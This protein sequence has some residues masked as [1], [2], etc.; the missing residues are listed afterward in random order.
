MKKAYK[1]FIPVVLLVAAI[2]S[3]CSSVPKVDWTL[4]ISGDVTN[5]MEISYKE[6]TQMS[7]T[8]LSD[9]MM[10]KSLGEDE[11]TSWS[12][13]TLESILAEAGAAEG[14]VS[15]TALAADGYAIEITN[16]EAEGA[17]VALKQSGEW[18]QEVDPDSGPIR[19]VCPQT[20]AN[21]WVFQ[22]Q[23]IKVNQ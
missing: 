4:K 17:I 12:G 9:I 7:Q 23:E 16:A 11:Y 8:D 15:I 18:I 19:L 10:D 22:L 3:A 13:V 20:P 5:P 21:R 6:L 2:F 1:R 14:F